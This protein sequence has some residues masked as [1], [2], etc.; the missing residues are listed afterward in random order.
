MSVQKDEKQTEAIC[1]VP[2]LPQVQGAFGKGGQKD[3][4][5]QGWVGGWRKVVWL[6]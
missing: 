6:Q 1:V 4:R 3:G 2:T 5:K